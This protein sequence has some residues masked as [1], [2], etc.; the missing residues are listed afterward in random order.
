MTMKKILDKVNSPEDI[1]E[2]NI[3]ELKALSNEIR[4]FLIESVI[5]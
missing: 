3:D 2:L 4:N 1:K 5:S